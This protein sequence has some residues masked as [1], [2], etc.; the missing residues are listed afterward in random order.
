MFFIG[1]LQ[2]RFFG[3][4]RDVTNEAACQLKISTKGE[5]IRSVL[6]R[7]G[8]KYGEEFRVKIWVKSDINWRIKMMV[9]EKGVTNQ[10]LD[11]HLRDG[12]E[13][14]LFFLVA[15]MGG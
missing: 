8:D 9:N 5:S 12:D 14:T 1:K 3:G 4:L 7:L 11:I 13:L 10:E 6:E 15:V 2:V